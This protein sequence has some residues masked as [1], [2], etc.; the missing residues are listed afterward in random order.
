MTDTGDQ[1]TLKPASEQTVLGRRSRHAV[2]TVCTALK[3]NRRDTDHRL[4]CQAHFYRLKRRITRGVTEPVTIG[5]D[6][7]IHKIG[8][9]E[10]YRRGIIGSII[11]LPAWRP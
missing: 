4:L 11:K 2:D 3:H 7:H 1:A 9:V 5:M 6:D 10:R 8:I